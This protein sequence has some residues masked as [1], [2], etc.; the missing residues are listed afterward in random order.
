MV[1][2]AAP[3]SLS[4]AGFHVFDLNKMARFYC[5]IFG[6]Q[7]TDRKAGRL[8]FLG[9]DP[10]DHHQ[11]LLVAGRTT[12]NGEKHYGHVA[13]R[14]PSL[15]R[16]REIKATL[17][18]DPDV[19]EI[20]E[21]THGNAWSVYFKDPEGNT[22]EAFID[23]PWHVKQPFVEKY[24]LSKSDKEIHVDTQKI[25]KKYKSTR[26]FADWRKD[27]AKKLGMTK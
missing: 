26:P 16:L 8:C 2:S 7:V 3:A 15:D 23:T 5:K 21:T 14:V 10:R 13:F 24:D 1:T 17:E 22:A 18:K 11:L 12:K 20:R 9:G 4:H 27:F 25:L 6:L 19:E